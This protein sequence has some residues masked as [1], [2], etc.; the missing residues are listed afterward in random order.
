M[1][2][3]RKLGWGTLIEVACKTNQNRRGIVFHIYKEWGTNG[4]CVSKNST[5]D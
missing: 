4:S 3:E 1:A 5:W 2:D